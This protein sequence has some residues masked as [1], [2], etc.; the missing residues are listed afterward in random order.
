MFGSLR[1]ASFGLAF[2]VT[3]LVNCGGSSDVP[4]AN[5]GTTGGAGSGAAGTTGAAGS[6][7]AGSAAA[8]SP[9]AAGTMGAAGT[10]GTAG[11][12]GGT[13]NVG[14][15]DSTPIACTGKGATDEVIVDFEDGSAS[16]KQSTVL[17]GSFYTFN[18]GTAG[19][20]QTPAP[21]STVMASEI[22]GGGRCSD[23]AAKSKYALHM[24]ASGFTNWGGLIGTDLA[25]LGGTPPRTTFDASAYTGVV[26]WARA[27]AMASAAKDRKVRF[28]LIDGDT[29]PDGGK[30]KQPGT[31][32]DAC[33]NDF[34]V[35]LTLTGEWTRYEVPF[36]SLKQSD[37][38]MRFPAFLKDKVYGMQWKFAKSVNLDIWIDDVAFY[39]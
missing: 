25:Y 22:C 12:T 30:C 36:T 26:F 19:G 10:T 32:V 20:V 34:G 21:M 13:T 8:G 7:A 15:C 5:G 39:K 11:A 4:S 33:Y 28:V 23:E 31:P 14:S 37:Y 35:D 16:L 29:D 24:V 27:G 1:H 17:N 18:D 9:G 2:V 6:S 3:G 38:G